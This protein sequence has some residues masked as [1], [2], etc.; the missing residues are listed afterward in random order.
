MK[1]VLLSL[2]MVSIATGP[3]FAASDCSFDKIEI[4]G[5]FGQTGLEMMDLRPT[6][7]VI[8]VAITT[9]AEI[10]GTLF[11]QKAD[12]VEPY[13][14]QNS[15]FDEA[16]GIL[17]VDLNP[18]CHW[19]DGQPIVAQDFIEAARIAYGKT[20]YDQPSLDFLVNGLA[21]KSGDLPFDDLGLTAIDDDTLAFTL[22]VPEQ[23]AKYVLSNPTLA[24]VPSHVMATDPD[25]WQRSVDELVFSGPYRI[26][27]FVGIAGI[28]LD[29]NPYFCSTPKILADHAT[30]LF[31]EDFE[32]DVD[33]Y[34]R[35][36][37]DLVGNLTARQRSTFL[38]QGTPEKYSLVE[39]QM[40][41][42]LWLELNPKSAAL[43][44]ARVREA[45]RLVYDR[46]IID[47][48]RIGEIG[49]STNSLTFRDNSYDG[50]VF[51][52][53]DKD[54]ASSVADARALMEQAGYS[55]S[56]RLRLRIAVPPQS[57]AVNVS[58]YLTG[59]YGQIYIDLEIINETPEQHVARVREPNGDY[60]LRTYYWY[61]DL[62]DPYNLIEAIIQNRFMSG[63]NI[64]ELTEILSGIS[65][66]NLN[67]RQA[68]LMRA[69]QLLIDDGHIMPL[70]VPVRTW[71]TRSS[72][73]FDDAILPSARDATEFDCK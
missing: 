16:T 52:W 7:A 15:S 6:S 67:D 2:A 70:G 55:N 48:G 37:I 47:T 19:S 38:E 64:D 14:A 36:G 24:P 11:L 29:R 12:R 32:K 40:R 50:P 3:S 49:H 33:K 5:W 41:S 44:D 10:H 51:P 66:T 65:G 22:A 9:A 58:E 13:L 39:G 56:D 72:I 68:A 21:V 17:Q 53:S 26:H 69:E 4:R 42:I 73:S 63:D 43:D 57:G 45:L 27:E 62:P 20:A 46:E 30:I 61:A 34:L 1:K 71:L 23:I 60:D 54:Y 59:A 8:S 31:G 25:Y 35:S 28:D 18:S